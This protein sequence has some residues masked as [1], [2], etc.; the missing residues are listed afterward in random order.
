M[1]TSKRKT[2]LELDYEMLLNDDHLPE[3]VIVPSSHKS[4]PKPD[5]ADEDYRM[6]TDDE[7][8]DMISKYNRL[9]LNLGP[10]CKDNGDK[11]KATD[12]AKNEE[13]MQLSGQT[14]D[15]EILMLHQHINFGFIG[16]SCRKDGS[17]KKSSVFAQMLTNKID[18]N[19]RTVNAFEKEMSWINPLQGRKTSLNGQVSNSGKSNQQSSSRLK[20]FKSPTNLF[21][22]KVTRSSVVSPQHFYHS[23]QPSTKLKPEA[24]TSYNL[25]DEEDIED[26]DDF[27]TTPYAEK[28]SDCMKD[29]KV[30]Y[31]SRDDRDPI[32]YTDMECLAPEACLSSTIMNFYIRYL[33]Q[34]S[35]ENRG[36]HY[37]LFN[38]YF[39][40][41]LQKFNYKEDSFLKFRKWWKGVSIFEKTYIL[42]PVHESAH[43]SLVII[44]ILTK[45]DDLGA[46]ILHLDSLGLHNSSQIFDN[47][48]R[49]VK[50]EWNH[51]TNSEDSLAIPVMDEIW[52]N[53]DP[54]I[55]RKIQV[56]QQR[57]SYDCGLFVLYYM[58]RFIKEAPERLK[59]EKDL[60][61]MFGKQWFPPKEAS[62]LRWRVQKLLVKEFNASKDNET[63]LSPT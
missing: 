18:G 4:K 11:L 35:S 2:G 9:L 50:E 6:K 40:N 33:Q 8:K 53:L 58:E 43:W 32:E 19:E 12:G 55:N 45:K 57:N 30:Y 13:P 22:K 52:E 39:Y 1:A 24:P 60:S 49:F 16:A 62:N 7:L 15:G 36:C 21:D 26:P 44:C 25:V 42:L 47:V 41:K 29:V 10:K 59:E 37:H 34:T 48:G 54:S 51:L 17:N 5:T 61:S 38:T 14:D 28:L 63:V 46:M 31:P 3:L 23:N 27:D 56:P 20:Q